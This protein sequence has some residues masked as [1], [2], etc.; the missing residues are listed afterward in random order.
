MKTSAL[1]ESEWSASQCS[2]FTPFGKEPLV[3]TRRVG[4]FGPHSQNKHGGKEKNSCQ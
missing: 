2:H 4:V 1:D 3:S